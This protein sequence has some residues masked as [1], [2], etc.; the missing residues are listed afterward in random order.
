MILKPA[1]GV[2]YSDRKLMVNYLYH[3]SFYIDEVYRSLRCIDDA[4]YY[5]SELYGGDS[6]KAQIQ[7]YRHHT[8]NLLN[9]LGMLIDSV[10]N[11]DKI[12]SCKGVLKFEFDKD[13]RNTIAHIFEKMSDLNEI[14]GGLHGFN[15]IFNE[16]DVFLRDIK[17]PVFNLDL[18]TKEITMITIDRCK[19]KPWKMYIT[20]LKLI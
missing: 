5:Q 12:V 15:V 7:Y 6:K 19:R 18:L 17:E 10:H 11:V 9:Y 1:D 14:T 2:G 20:I 4:G 13:T 16:E 8:W 3:I